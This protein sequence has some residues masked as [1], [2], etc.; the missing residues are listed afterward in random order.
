MEATDTPQGKGAVPVNIRILDKEYTVGCGPD[1]R[2]AL[3]AAANALDTRMRE[4]RGA[5]RMAALDRVMLLAALNFI[6]E[7]HSVQQRDRT[8]ETELTGMLQ[9]LTEKLDALPADPSV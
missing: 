4:I 6:S 8:R 3:E 7:L 5:N 1:E 2:A 9:S